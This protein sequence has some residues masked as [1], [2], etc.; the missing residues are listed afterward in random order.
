MA[1]CASLLDEELSSFV[2]NYL[3]E[4]SGSQYGEEE[5]SSDHLDAD[6]PDI[7]LSQLD[8]SDFNCLSELHWCSEQPDSSPSST[9]YHTGDPEFLEIE[10]ENAALLAALTDSLDSMVEDEV[11]GLSVFP[12]LTDASEDEEE[13][14]EDSM[15]SSGD[16]CSELGSQQ[17]LRR[18]LPLTKTE[19][20]ASQTCDAEEPSLLE[21]LLLTPP[22]VP[23]GLDSQKEASFRSSHS[24][25]RNHHL[26]PARPPLKTGKRAGSLEAKS[27]AALRPAG[28]LCTEL[29]RHLT[30]ERHQLQTEEEGE[31]EEE[32]EEE[33]LAEEDEEEED[34]E[35]EEEED[36]E[37]DEEEEES[38]SSEGESGAQ[39]Q[40]ILHGPLPAP[41][42][43]QFSSE[44]ELHSVV[45][46]VKYMHTYCVPSR[47]QQA[48]WD[49]KE[50]EMAAAAAAASS[51]HR[52]TST[53][54]SSSSSSL[55]RSAGH[56]HR[57]PTTTAGYAHH[58]S[59]GA[60]VVRPR[61]AFTRQRDM[62]AFTLLKQLLEAVNPF[63]VSK[64]YRYHSA[65][66]AS[67]R[68]AAA[69]TLNSS[70][71]IHQQQQG[72]QLHNKAT[73][74]ACC[75]SLGSAT[76]PSVAVLQT[77]QPDDDAASF[78]V[79][80][81][82]RLASFPSR[83][84]KR[85]R[86]LHISS[87][88]PTPTPT[89]ALNTTTPPPTHNAPQGSI[90]TATEENDLQQK[91]P[92]C[93]GSPLCDSENR[94]CLC[95]PLSLKSTGDSQYANKPF[96]ATLS[97]E[98]CGTAGLT[99]PTTPPHKPVEEELFKPEG[100]GAEL[101]SPSPPSRGGGG[102]LSRPHARK[103]PEQTE[104]YAQLQRMGQAEYTPPS[105]LRP[106]SLRSY[107]D[108]DYCLLNLTTDS[109]KRPASALLTAST[110]V[111]I[112]GHHPPP[113]L[114]SALLT[115]TSPP[116]LGLL[117]HDAHTNNRQVVGTP[118]RSG[119]GDRLCSKL[120]RQRE[121]EKEGGEGGGGGGGRLTLRT[122]GCSSS[123]SL[124]P[125]ALSTRNVDEDTVP[126]PP[127]P[128]S[129]SPGNNM[130]PSTP[131]CQPHSPSGKASYS[132]ENSET[133]HGDKQRYKCKTV[134]QNDDDCRVFY[135]HNL[136]S[137]V[138]QS[139]L[140]KRFEAFGDP[141]DCRVVIKNDRDRCG[142]I[143]F[144]K[145]QSSGSQRYRTGFQNGSS[146][147][148]RLSRKRY[149]DLDEAGPGPVKSKYDSMDFDTLLKEAQKS[150]HR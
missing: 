99:P 63:D 32:E 144:R 82:R 14:E 127:P 96:E 38:F 21:K 120:L 133:C 7:D 75:N 35:S 43:P 126:L 118:E 74:Q 143:T 70:S 105:L 103:L 64:P 146:G 81:S 130:R 113:G 3:T 142:V 39:P 139:M 134:Q 45:E 124:T 125:Q 112:T 17:Q 91:S 115:P 47:K 131:C 1:D 84:A 110:A 36:A 101:P 67:A 104:L 106:G 135:I 4:N 86:P 15:E 9:H 33:D 140:R 145:G 132:C 128:R 100:K 22:N 44:R 61:L 107:G 69:A 65:P 49:R 116:A 147:S 72:L 8:T 56:C 122:T 89:L 136:P 2:F 40:G 150:L 10:E 11:V 76:E 24:S 26:R 73:Q 66:Y 25:S 46:L 148:R 97:V 23:V 71:C 93:S 90:E 50:R 149:I 94:S 129:P 54:P 80:R 83:F 20:L 55:P 102:F 109:R 37:E 138:T 68:V 42:K 30:T 57:G 59:N 18:R 52:R 79:R 6:F 12:S 13:E 87:G 117:S 48:S 88:S 123:A 53:T 58:Q 111:S 137:S 141:K 77:Q 114:A 51:G 121:E 119:S 41:P 62:R 27:R 78:S 19:I 92:V 29:H 31:E 95:L 34:S 28:R 16:G 98:L 5:V 60:A 85:S 108:H